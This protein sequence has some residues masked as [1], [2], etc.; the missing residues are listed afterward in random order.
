MTLW[1]S[2][3]ILE[4]E[5]TPAIIFGMPRLGKTTYS[6][7]VGFRVCKLAH[8]EWTDE[9]CWQYVFDHMFFKL[10]DVIEFFDK[11]NSDPSQEK[12]L[13]IIVDDAGVSMGSSLFFEDRHQA[14]LMKKI[15]DVAGTATKALLLTT[16]NPDELLKTVKKAENYRIKIT[17]ANSNHERRAR[18]Y[19]MVLLPSGTQNV[20]KICDDF[21]SI[22]LPDDVYKKYI[23]IRKKYFTEGITNMKEHMLEKQ[24]EKLAKIAK[25]KSKD[26]VKIEM[27]NFEE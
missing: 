20:R 8:P 5:Y 4:G 18:I 11:I 9:Q 13:F 6:M 17:K 23:P 22:L 1:L 7:K 14:G 10:N 27:E 15:L 3:K 16:P 24:A 21:Y 2:D 19:K 26:K 25:R 12:C